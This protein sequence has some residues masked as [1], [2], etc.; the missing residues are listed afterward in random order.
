MGQ[1]FVSNLVPLIIGMGLFP[2]LPLYAAQFGAT[3]TQVGLLYSG[4]YAGSVAGSA[5][6]GWLGGRLPPRTMFVLSGA[7]ACLRSFCWATPPRSGRL[8]WRRP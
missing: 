7:L 5:V 2:I 3:S 4:T 1:L 6:A 8:C